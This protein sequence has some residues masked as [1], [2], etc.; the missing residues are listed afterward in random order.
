MSEQELG[1]VDEAGN[2]YVKTESGERLVGQ[3]ADVPAEEALA[4]FTRKFADVAQ[5]VVLLEQR[6]KRS[7]PAN[8]IKTSLVSVRKAVDAGVGVGDFAKLSARLDRVAEALSELDADEV[9]KN[10]EATDAAKA[11]RLAIVEAMESLAGQDPLKVQWKQATATADELFAKWQDHQKSAPRLSK[12]ESNELWKRFRDARSTID[13]HRRSHFAELDSRNKGAKAAKEALVT[14]A[15]ELATAGPGGIPKYRALLDEWKISPRAGKKIDDA[16]WARFKAAGDVLYGAKAE[17]DA[18][19]DESFA[20]NLVIKLELLADAEKLMSVTDRVQARQSLNTIQK[21]WDAAGKVP[22]AQV[23]SIEDRMRK[24]EATVRGLEDNHWNASNPE[25]QAR[26]E[27][28]AGQLEV[29]IGKL[30]VE[31]AA[32][33]AA[34][35]S[36]AVKEIT[37]AISTQK[38][39]LAIL[40]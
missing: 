16:L 9:V 10:T 25:K 3:Y 40:K 28:L 22:R 26:S 24:V 1:R 31:L 14:K 7:A 8:E 19:E 33:N 15:E 13:Q 30:E 29:K 2:V 35:N 4:F 32:A 38:A 27:G 20:A 5:S 17:E 34:K 6:V 11:D 36:K 23:K 37:E 39:W 21:K 12:T 18:V